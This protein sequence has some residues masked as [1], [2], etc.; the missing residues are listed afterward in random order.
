MVFHTSWHMKHRQQFFQPLVAKGA[1]VFDIGANIGEF[2]AAFLALDA[3][4][5][6]AVEPQP[7]L[8]RHL[9]QSFPAAIAQGKLEVRPC[10]VSSA[11]GRLRLNVASDPGRSMSTLSPEFLAM[12]RRNGH[13]WDAAAAIDVDVVTLAQLIAAHG[14]PDYLKIDVEGHDLAVLQGLDRP[15][16]LLSFEFNTDAALI[17]LAAACIAHV[18]SLGDYEFNFQA[19]AP[20]MV[21]LQLSP[22]VSAEVMSYIILNDVSRNPVYG[23]V[24]CRLRSR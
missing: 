5:V 15:V 13:H 8:C 6:V 21:E 2:T 22:W 3:G 18:A 4:K 1:V 16:A 24:F 10:A 9:A 14:T 20:G 23:D 12:S 11:P 7:E 17:G 19:D